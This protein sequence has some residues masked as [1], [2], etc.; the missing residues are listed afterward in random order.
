MFHARS[1]AARPQASPAQSGGEVPKRAP[2]THTHTRSH[3]AKDHKY[4]PQ[5]GGEGFLG[6]HPA[7]SHTHGHTPQKTTQASPESGGG[8]P[9]RA[10]STLT[11]PARSHTQR[12]SIFVRQAHGK[13]EVAGAVEVDARRK[14]INATEEEED[15]P[16][17]ILSMCSPT[18]VM[19]SAL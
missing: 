10:P 11:H 16:N 14:E 3:A 6:A 13:V 17:G 4:P 8:V 1:H 19:K 9:G 15:I 18:A 2:S 7:L 5:S 12:Q